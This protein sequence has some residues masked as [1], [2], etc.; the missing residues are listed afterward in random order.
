MSEPIV[1]ERVIAASPSVVF[2]YLTNSEKWARWQGD[3]ATIRPE[4][5]GIFALS[6]SNG[7]RARGQFVEVEQDR[8]VVFTWGWVDHPGVPPGST[9]VEIELFAE[10][11]G[12]RLRLTHDGLPPDEV[13]IHTAGWEH[14]AD[15][16]VTTAEG[17]DPGPDVLPG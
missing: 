15:R 7:T 9:T 6:M 8:R 12:T 17:R 14:Y 5:G 3:H 13:A 16:L 1:L 2:S 10:G 4:R 11:D